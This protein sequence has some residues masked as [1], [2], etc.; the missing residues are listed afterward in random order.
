MSRPF[1]LEA[2]ARMRESQRD[3][4]RAQL[5]DALQAAE[6]LSG[7]HDEVLRQ[8]DVLLE[9]RR[10]ATASG[11][12][13]ANWLLNAGRYELVLRAD[14]GRILENVRAIETE[15]DR[16]RELLANAEREVRALELLRERDERKAREEQNR[17]AARRLDEFASQRAY[18]TAQQPPSF[19]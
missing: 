11:T 14:E 9:Q 8:C 6:V 15:I 5:A 1:R 17:R 3:A 18:Q 12:A 4:A 10:V 13:D 7:R 19:T 2:V 16:R